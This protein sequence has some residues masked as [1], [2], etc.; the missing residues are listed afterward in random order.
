MR[1]SEVTKRMREMLEL[2]S[3]E[4]NHFG[5]RLHTTPSVSGLNDHGANDR[6]IHAVNEA[7]PHHP[8]AA[9]GRRF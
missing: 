1:L 7:E 4:L 9:F 5:G 8:N 6:Q 3:D 2:N